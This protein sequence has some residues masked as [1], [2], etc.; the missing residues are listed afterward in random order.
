MYIAVIIIAI[1]ILTVIGAFF[2]Y[3][4]INSLRN[5]K[6]YERGLKMVTMQIHLPPPS[7]DLEVGSRDS[8]DL[9][10]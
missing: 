8:R 2:G 3:I 5:T 10:E 4:H 1:V 6:N 9:N 7:E